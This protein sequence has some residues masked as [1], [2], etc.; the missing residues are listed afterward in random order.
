M[1]KIS[2]IIAMLLMSLTFGTVLCQANIPAP[3]A[4]QDLGLWDRTIN[5]MSEAD[6]RGCHGN[7]VN[8]LH[9]KL[10]TTKK[11]SCFT[12]HKLDYISGSWQFEPFRDCLH[13]HSQ[14]AGQASVH[15]IGQTA[16]EGN[17]AACHGSLVQNRDDGHYIPTYGES[18]V[19]PRPSE[20]TGTNG[21]GAC[22]YCHSWGNDLGTSELVYANKETH[23]GTGLGYDTNKCTWCHDSQAGAGLKIRSCEQCHA[24]Q[25]LHNIQLDTNS[26]GNIIP[27]AELPY[28]GHIGNNEDCLG[29]HGGSASQVS[30]GGGSG[31]WS[32]FNPT[33]H[34]L[35][36][37]K[38][39]KKCLD[40][41]TLY[42]NVQGIFVFKDFRTCSACHRNG[43]R[44]P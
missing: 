1:R 16:Q 42:R 27:G 3:P 26:D 29:C 34:H 33:R 8:E 41:H 40:C 20:G 22:D 44:R 15:H 14:I 13:C 9:H 28:K 12:C 30:I 5:N 23:H 37:Q 10:I 2:L 31:G 11:L 19:T 36:V 25:S 43:G 6:C 35:L 18:M 24:P 21:K 38:K 7:V 17:C 4:D 39:G 32:L